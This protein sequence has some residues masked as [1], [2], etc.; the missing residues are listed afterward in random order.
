MRGGERVRAGRWTWVQE[1]GDSAA[2]GVDCGV[3][4]AI[5]A[6]SLGEAGDL[7]RLAA[8]HQQPHTGGVREQRFGGMGLAGGVGG[9][10]S[11]S[12][13]TAKLGTAGA[14]PVDP[15]EG[16]RGGVGEYDVTGL[17]L[18]AYA[19]QQEMDGWQRGASGGDGAG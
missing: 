8:G 6:Q 11:E 3:D 16:G 1:I 10:A 15:G 9:G 17:Q 18:G 2:A 5:S 4:G 19:I 13:H 7:V 12:E 14:A